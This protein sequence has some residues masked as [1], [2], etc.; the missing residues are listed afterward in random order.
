M[1]TAENDTQQERTPEQAP[2]AYERVS[3]RMCSG[4]RL[5]V[6]MQDPRNLRWFA[7]IV[8]DNVGNREGDQNWAITLQRVAEAATELETLILE[9]WQQFDPDSLGQMLQS[10]FVRVVSEVVPHSG[11]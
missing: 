2:P 4:P 7:F 11:G 1:C 8:L 6:I 5:P 10:G 3:V 9:N